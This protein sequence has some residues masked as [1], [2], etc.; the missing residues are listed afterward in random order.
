MRAIFAGTRYANVTST[1]ALIVA[2]GGTGAYAASKITSAD[3]GRGQVKN[4]NLAN[5]AVT[6]AKVANGSLLARD[7]A[8]GQLR[9][10]PSGATG[11][12]GPAGPAGPAGSAG[13]AGSAGPALPDVLPKGQTL[14]GSYSFS[15]FYSGA[16][17]PHDA[18]P[19]DGQISF[20]IP[21]AAAPT[22][23]LIRRKQPQNQEGD[24]TA[25]C[26]GSVLN[27]QAAPGYLCVYESGMADNKA[28][29]AFSPYNGVNGVATRFGVGLYITEPQATTSDHR[30]SKGSWAV[31]AP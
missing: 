30:T 31:T 2:L 15:G 6:S 17:L 16:N 9:A 3:I 22:V 28:L 10:G 20:P 1:L 5:G 4:A 29:Y 13:S 27:P 14:R 26:P 19:S 18:G 24:P 25:Q 11:A 8:Q 12:Q 7:F 23:V 21:L